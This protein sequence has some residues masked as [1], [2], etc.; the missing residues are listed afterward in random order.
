MEKDTYATTY[1]P[2]TA[3][4]DGE[5]YWRVKARI[6]TAWE[7]YA[8]AWTFTKDWSGGGTN[9]P[10]LLSPPEGAVR[11][12]FQD[13]DFSWSPMDGAATYRLEISID[14]GFG[15]TAYTATTLK[16]QHTPTLRLPNN[17]YFWR[18][19]PTDYRGNAGVAEPDGQL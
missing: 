6:G 1:T 8:N 15:S 5:Y 4:A 2:E 13:P 18:V 16:T 11:A 17:D 10:Q 14:P 19:V 7:A 3:F 9:V 12:S